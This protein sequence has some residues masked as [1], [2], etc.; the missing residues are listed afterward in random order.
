MIEDIQQRRSSTARVTPY[1]RASYVR[2]NVPRGQIFAQDIRPLSVNPVVKPVKS[3]A[4]LKTQIVTPKAPKRSVVKSSP[5]TRKTQR[6]KVMMRQLVNKPPVKTIKKTKRSHKRQ[7]LVLTTMAALVFL[8]GLGVSFDGWRT[9]KKIETQ[10]AHAVAS[11]NSESQPTDAPSTDKPDTSAITS[12]AVAPTMPRYFKMPQHGISKARVLPMAVDANN[13]LKSPGNVHDVGWYNASAQP[14][15]AGA[16]LLDAHV[17]SWT[18]NGVFYHIKDLKPG[19][20]VSVERG[21][22]TEFTYRIVKSQTYDYKNVDMTAA[23]TPVTAGKPGLNMIT[24]TGKVIP[25]T[26]EFDKRI[27]VFAEQ[28]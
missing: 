21:D 11:N 19:D 10:V 22:G 18:T 26:N 5:A 28:V 17:S 7:S 2:R 27:V 16:M 1:R 8:V 25:G 24:C 13:V 15:N 14:G 6:S 23:I 4:I 12:Y 20:T 9:N 3:N